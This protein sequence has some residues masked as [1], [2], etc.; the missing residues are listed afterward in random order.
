MSYV[1]GPKG[2]VVI[3]KDLRDLLGIEPGWIALQ[4]LAV[5][6]IEVYFVPP[7]HRK[8]LKGQLARHIRTHIAQG[9]EWD[10]ARQKAWKIALNGE[11][12][13]DKRTNA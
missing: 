10:D 8:S 11:N 5:D 2:Q 3:S 4:R 1:V 9:P 13:T 12:N 6:H 7:L